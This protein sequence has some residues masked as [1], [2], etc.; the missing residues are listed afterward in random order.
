MPPGP[1]RP[2]SSLETIDLMKYKARLV[3]LVP[4]VYITS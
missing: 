3:I 2:A 1:Q 4:L